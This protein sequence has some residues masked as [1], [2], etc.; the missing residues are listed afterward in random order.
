MANTDFITDLNFTK[1][2]EGSKWTQIW[3]EGLKDKIKDVLQWFIFNCDLDQAM[4]Y[5]PE[6]F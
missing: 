5:L 2:T 3:M 1:V 6:D 4:D